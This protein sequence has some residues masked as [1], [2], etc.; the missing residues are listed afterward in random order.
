[1]K[2]MHSSIRNRQCKFLN[3]QIFSDVLRVQEENSEIIV[4]HL[5]NIPIYPEIKFLGP[6][7]SPT[8]VH[9]GPM[10]TTHHE[11]DSVKS[12]REGYMWKL[13]KF[14]VRPC[15]P[16]PSAGSAPAVAA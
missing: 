2:F 11:P 10:I 13:E 15:I 9:A 3:S 7:F 6:T 4:I 8:A 1:M 16:A 5:L 14:G 12:C